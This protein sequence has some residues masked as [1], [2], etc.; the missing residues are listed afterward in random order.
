MPGTTPTIEN[1]GTEFLP[2]PDVGCS[3]RS[4]RDET[5][6]AKAQ[7]ESAFQLKALIFQ[8]LAAICIS[9]M[10]LVLLL[11]GEPFWL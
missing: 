3:K 6:K 9:R 5:G 7:Y 11:S 4:L 8:I 2:D 1:T 10:S